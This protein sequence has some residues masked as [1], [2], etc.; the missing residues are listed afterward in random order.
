MQFDF[1]VF[2]QF[3][4]YFCPIFHLKKQNDRV[5]FLQGPALAGKSLLIE[6]VIRK[7]F[8]NVNVG[9]ISNIKN[10]FQ[11]STLKDKILGIINEFSS[12]FV[13]T[14]TLKVLL[15]G[16]PMTVAEKFMPTVEINIPWHPLLHII[17]ISNDNI[18]SDLA[19]QRRLAPFYLHSLPDT[20]TRAKQIAFQKYTEEMAV[21][22]LNPT[23]R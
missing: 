14:P 22:K 7:V 19:L 8:N 15:E 10:D 5:I 18:P 1:S 4:T 20:P 21:Q 3:I 16:A 2:K 12:E 17:I 23:S 9:M 11:F 13:N 6:L